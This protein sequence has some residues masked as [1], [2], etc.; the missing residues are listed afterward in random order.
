MSGWV[1]EEDTAMDPSIRD[2]AVSH[3]SKLL[4]KIRRMLILDLQPDKLEL[5][6]YFAR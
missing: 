2:E 3:R 1:D 4:A 6:V 5:V